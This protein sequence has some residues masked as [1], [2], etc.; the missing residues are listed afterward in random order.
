M[1]TSPLRRACQT[2]EAIAG[3]R[4]IIDPR[5]MEMDFGDL[6]GRPVAEVRDL[7]WDRWA[8]D[9]GWAPAGGESLASVTRRVTEACEEL[10]P[11]IA[12]EDVVVV[13]HVSP[14]KAAVAWALDVTP[15]IAGRMFVR[16]ASIT[17][18]T[19]GFDGRPV[20]AAFGVSAP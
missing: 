6:E 14:I 11:R 5:W 15:L 18:V 8:D 13:T 20:L 1:I 17:T 9:V 3:S 16:E 4:P 10:L 7:L 12:T 19:C 2:A